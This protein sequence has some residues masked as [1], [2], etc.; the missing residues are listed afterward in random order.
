M[1]GA[2]GT[3]YFFLEGSPAL[4]FAFPR[5]W[6]SGMDGCDG[7]ERAHLLRSVLSLLSEL[8]GSP[9]DLLAEAVLG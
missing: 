6:L 3:V 4:A 9:G 7:D 5:T 1:C 2:T 8:S